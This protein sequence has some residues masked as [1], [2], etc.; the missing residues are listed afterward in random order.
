MYTNKNHFIIVIIIISQK[1]KYIYIYHVF[2]TI[3]AL[4]TMV[5]PLL[6]LSQS[7]ASMEA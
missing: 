4:D 7:R 5:A 6:S 2:E 1:G 3:K